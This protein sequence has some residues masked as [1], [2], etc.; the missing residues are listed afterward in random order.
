MLWNGKTDFLLIVSRNL[1]FWGIVNK[2]TSTNPT[3]KKHDI[4]H[5]MLV[6]LLKKAPVFNIGRYQCGDG[7]S[8]VVV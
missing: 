2:K 6:F 7:L 3:C 4:A 5:I 1:G 8:F